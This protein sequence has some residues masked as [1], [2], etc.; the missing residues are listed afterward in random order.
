MLMNDNYPG[1]ELISQGLA[2][3]RAHRLSVSALLVAIG[4][5]RLRHLILDI[6]TDE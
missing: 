1:A 4:A 2:D 5:P 3:L 6:P